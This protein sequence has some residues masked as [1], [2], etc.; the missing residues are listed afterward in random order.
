MPQEDN[1]EADMWGS[2]IHNEFQIVV[3]KLVINNP[4]N[5]SIAL[6]IVTF[7]IETKTNMAKL[8]YNFRNYNYYLSWN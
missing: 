8:L 2:E 1:Q 4:G 5:T 6:W 7:S 3:K